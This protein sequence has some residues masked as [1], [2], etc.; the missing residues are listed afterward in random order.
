L[1]TLFLVLLAS[2]STP[3]V[4]PRWFTVRTDVR[5]EDGAPLRHG[6]GVL[7]V[8][9]RGARLR[10]SEG[11]WLGADA[12]DPASPVASAPAPVV[13]TDRPAEITT[14]RWIDVDVATQRLT[15]YEG[16]T[17]VRA[18]AI[19][20]GAG[21]DGQMFSTPK[22]TFHVYAKLRSATMA[23]EPDDPHPYRFEAVPDV[24]YFDRE[25]A[26]HGAYWHHRFGERI[27]HGCVNL[28]P[29]DAAWLFDFTSPQLT[30]SEKERAATGNTG[31][32]VRVR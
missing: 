31:T 25:I 22:G 2:C 23:S 17:P 15:A 20:S 32:L 16:A 4:E 26:L 10:T 12:L 24:Q 3:R 30:P 28:A 6:S 5:A 13:R 1:R 11:H 9:A 18:F 14:Q 29:G 8:E 19:S 7:I 21:A 27:S